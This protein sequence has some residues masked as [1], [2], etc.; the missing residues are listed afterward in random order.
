MGADFT[1]IDSQALLEKASAGFQGGLLTDA[2][3]ISELSSVQLVPFEAGSTFVGRVES[4]QWS[5]PTSLRLARI[6]H[7]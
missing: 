1:F 3:Y 4:T 5:V 6:Q 7:R 2:K